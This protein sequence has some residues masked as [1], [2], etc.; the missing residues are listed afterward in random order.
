MITVT[1]AKALGHFSVEAS[2]DLPAKGVTALFGPS[3]A[4]KTSMINMVA[5]LLR[6]DRGAIMV[7]ERCLFDADRGIDLPP[8]RRRI[9][10]VFQDGRLFPHLSVYDNL[11]YGMHRVTPCQRYVDPKQVI[12]LL[13]I[14]HLLARRPATLSGGEKQRVA[15]GRALLTSPEL[16]LMD[17]PL[18][19]LDTARKAEL[20]PFIA[21][22]GDE[23]TV[24]ILY[25]SHAWDEIVA[26]ADTLL[27]VGE[28]R[29]TAAAGLETLVAD[30]EL[31]RLVAGLE[32]GALFNTVVEGHEQDL[33]I[34][35]FAGGT[36]RVPRG[37]WTP[38]HF[39]RIFIPA[40][41]VAISLDRPKRS[42]FQN[43]L[44]A[45]IDTIVE[46]GEGLAEV[47]MYI[48]CALSARITQRALRD[49]NLMP[50]QN[51]F[52]LIKSVGVSPVA[53]RQRPWGS[54]VPS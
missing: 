38:G 7:N 35:K 13:G 19:A 53:A 18:A 31:H 21:R 16:L 22:L 36:L 49:L 42:S 23:Y 52:A 5:G 39:L 11:T 12:R 33:T 10:Y 50:G 41:H 44:P 2:F 14:D 20:L 6:P 34:L 40:R 17:E 47:S 8:E 28:G 3:G 37:D 15:I 54:E 26:L 46:S 4:G 27:I 9:G 48:G 24:P 51:V 1:V 29:V 25:V 45:R 43:I 30:L 32:N